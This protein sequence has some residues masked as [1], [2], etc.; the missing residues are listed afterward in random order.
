MA[1]V[2]WM[3][4]WHRSLKATCQPIEKGGRHAQRVRADTATKVQ[5]AKL[6]QALLIWHRSEELHR[7]RLYGEPNGRQHGLSQT[8]LTVVYFGSVVN[9]TMSISSLQ[10]NLQNKDVSIK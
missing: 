1:A 9:V 8:G 5:K 3:P 2:Q 7:D 4:C 10:W 6:V